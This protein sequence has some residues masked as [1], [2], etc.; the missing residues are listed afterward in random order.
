MP[1][2]EGDGNY[3]A[4]GGAILQKLWEGHKWKEIKNCPGRYVSP[5]NRTICSLTPTE[6]LDSLIGSVRW[7]P[8]TSTT[9]P[10]AVVGRLG[11]RVISRGAHMTASTSKDA[12]WF[13]AFCDG[14]GL[15]TYEKADGIFVHTLNTESGLMRK[16]DAVA[17]SEL[18]QALQLNK[19]DGWILNVL[20]FLD[21]A[22]LNA[23]AYPLIVATKRFL[24]YFLITEL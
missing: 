22:S 10:S 23:G 3:I 16:I 24:N 1:A 14:G 15:I 18:S 21:D 17:A 13:F 6:V 4:D 7:V 11:S 20:S 2:F 8:V 12:C 19:I 9:T 5:R